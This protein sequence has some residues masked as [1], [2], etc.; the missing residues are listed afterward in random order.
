LSDFLLTSQGKITQAIQVTYDS[1]DEIIE[2]DIK[3]EM[4]PF[5]KWSH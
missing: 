1:E 2:D 5:Y 4:I 3:I